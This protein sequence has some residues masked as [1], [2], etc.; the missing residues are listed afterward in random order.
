M[1][2]VVIISIFFFFRSS[3]HAIDELKAKVMYL[4]TQVLH[5]NQE[6]DG[7]V[8]KFETENDLL[9]RVIQELDCKKVS[10]QRFFVEQ[11]IS[12]CAWRYITI[13]VK[14]SSANG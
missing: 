8:S 4:K 13:Y 1:H 10:R 7:L 14:V 5:L 3:S 12:N 11:I 2:F 9:S 6:R